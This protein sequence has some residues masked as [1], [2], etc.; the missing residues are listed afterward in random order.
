MFSCFKLH[1]CSLTITGE[2]GRYMFRVAS[3]SHEVN[4]DQKCYNW[5]AAEMRR[6]RLVL[7]YWRWTRP[8]PCDKRLAWMDGRWRADYIQYYNTRGEKMC[9]YERIPR[10]QSAQVRT[11]SITC[12]L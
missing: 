2:Q 12:S 7:F 10:W 4:Y 6:W 8:C 11:L 5:H 1:D 9:Y 3:G